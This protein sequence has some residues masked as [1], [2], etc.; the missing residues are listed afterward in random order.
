VI[1]QL[2]LTAEDRDLILRG[3]L[4]KLFKL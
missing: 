4:K 2:D 3:N 1:D